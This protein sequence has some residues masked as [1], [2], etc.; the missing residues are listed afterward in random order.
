MDHGV[1][2][3]WVCTGL[4]PPSPTCES[5]Q[6][7]RQPEVCLK[8]WHPYPSST[9]GGTQCRA[10]PR[11][12]ESLMTCVHQQALVA[13]TCFEWSWRPNPMRGCALA[14]AEGEAPCSVME[15]F[16]KVSWKAGGSTG[17]SCWTMERRRRHDATIDA[18]PAG[19]RDWSHDGT[20][21]GPMAAWFLADWTTGAG[22][23]GASVGVISPVPTAPA[24]V[25][26]RQCP[27]AGR[28]TSA[29]TESPNFPRQPMAPPQRHR[30]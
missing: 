8:S 9:P 3:H 16:W 7:P 17:R 1:I 29:G 4:F 18:N 22:G 11:G 13:G 24:P 14:F 27:S 12:G 21:T 15:A 5:Q 20:T 6:R 10:G 2:W 30:T 23:A 28:A 26:G 19:G 25:P